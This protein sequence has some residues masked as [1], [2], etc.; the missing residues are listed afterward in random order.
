M[1]QRCAIPFAHSTSRQGLSQSCILR[2]VLSVKYLR[3]SFERR[4]PIIA[5]APNPKLAKYTVSKAAA[6]AFGRAVVTAA[7]TRSFKPRSSNVPADIAERRSGTLSGDRPAPTAADPTMFGNVTD[8][9]LFRMATY[10]VIAIEPP[11]L[12]MDARRPRAAPMSAGFKKN[13]ASANEQFSMNPTN[14]GVVSGHL[15]T[16][17]LG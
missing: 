7:V 15:F 13:G 11:A 5:I 6:Y 1:S 8:N 17:N 2:S 14:Y 3:A 10:T 9:L 4:L 16:M 12:R